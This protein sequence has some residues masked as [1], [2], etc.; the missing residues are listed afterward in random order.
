MDDNRPHITDD[1][2][3]ALIQILTWLWLTFSLLFAIAQFF[4][5]WTLARRPALADAILTFALICASAQA[6]TVLSTPGRV[7][8]KSHA[9]LDDGQI[10]DALKILYASDILTFFSLAITK[11][12]VLVAFLDI[13]PS[14]SH[15]LGIY[16]TGGVVVAWGIAAVFTTA[17]QCPA[18]DRWDAT[19]ASCTNIATAQ[20]ALAS[21]MILTDAALVAIP[22]VVV[23]P[24]KVKWS[25]RLT[26]LA[27]FWARI[28]VI[29][30]TI[31]YIV[32]L[33]QLPRDGDYLL[34]VTKT[35]LCKETIQM[36]SIL[37]ATIPFLK[38][39]LISLESGFLRAD[40][41]NRRVDTTAY[42]SGDAPSKPTKS[43]RSG[44]STSKYVQI[45]DKHP[46]AQPSIELRSTE[47]RD[48][49]LLEH[50]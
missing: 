7:I 11:A 26:V 35:L 19:R 45:P 25:K 49:T 17:F 1:D 39:F 2:L 8:G 4:T 38:P 29:A 3:S 12:S 9:L 28:F 10:R 31:V 36:T 27:G 13:T 33:Q 43:G 48:A 20:T 40:D 18:P 34:D 23:V 44:R 37:A 47:S 24:L 21:I 46:S 16:I 15:R 50:E 32:F 5:K 30:A 6:A 14:R 22:T 42:G 41:E